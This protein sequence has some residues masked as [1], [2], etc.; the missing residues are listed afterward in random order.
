MLLVLATVP[1][2]LNSHLTEIITICI[3]KDFG[4]DIITLVNCSVVVWRED[5]NFKF[6]V[7]EDLLTYH[8]IFFS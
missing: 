4:S 6:H 8:I 5:L 2:I 1:K 3:R 7:I